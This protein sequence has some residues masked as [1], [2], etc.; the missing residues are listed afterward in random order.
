MGK[1]NLK[2]YLRY[3]EL[4]AKWIEP[5][6]YPKDGILKRITVQTNQKA[7]KGTFYITGYGWMQA[8]LENGIL[9]TKIDKALTKSRSRIIVSVGNK[10]KTKMRCYNGNSI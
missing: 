1:T 10:I 4:D 5:L 2:R 8:K 6:T 9:D 3:K 7:K